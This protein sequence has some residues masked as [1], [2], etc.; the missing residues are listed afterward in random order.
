MTEVQQAE[1]KQRY[2]AAVDS[3]VA[4]VKDDPNVIAV[5]VSG[6]LAYDL[7]WEKSDIDM[8]VVIRDQVLKNHSYSIIEDGIII[9]VNLTTRSN[10]KRDLEGS[11]GGSFF[12]SYLA[13]GN[14]VY[15][16][17]DSLNEFFEEQ[18]IMGKD[19]I[20]HSAFLIAAELIDLLE[21][22]Q[23][24]LLARKDPLYAQY[25]LLKAAEVVARMELCLNGE[26]V[27]RD[28]IQK[29]LA[30]N[31]DAITPFYQEAMSHQFSAEEVREGI[32]RLY[33][34]LEQRLDTLSRPVLEFMADQEIKTSTLIAKHFNIHPHFVVNVFD[35]LADKGVIERVS[36][37]IRIT[38]KSKLAHEELGY[39]Y[40]PE[41]D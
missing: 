31:P 3:F 6:S 14:V 8:T 24:W 13:K 19:D 35:Y 28:V 16:S 4:N 1:L 34:Y 18:K 22:A 30:I 33:N 23:K 7:L 11:F 39:L 25:Y 26:P 17:D 2:L 15:S 12:Q 29:A 41:Y 20:A 27:A 10:F 5:I 37:T 38:P 36:Q 32:N 9:N 21:K 40:I